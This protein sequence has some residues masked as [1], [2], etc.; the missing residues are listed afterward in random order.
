MDLLFYLV[1]LAVLVWA[2]RRTAK[3]AAEP[4]IWWT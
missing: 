4:P 3:G 1:C 2:D